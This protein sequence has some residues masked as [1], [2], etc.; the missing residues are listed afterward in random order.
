M[1]SASATSLEEGPATAT[2]NNKLMANGNSRPGHTCEEVRKVHIAVEPP[3]GG[4]GWIVVLASF[5]CN[6]T[7]DGESFRRWTCF[8][9]CSSINY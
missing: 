2:N 6:L 5:L 9:A 8:L 4:Y 7:V 1:A 3:D